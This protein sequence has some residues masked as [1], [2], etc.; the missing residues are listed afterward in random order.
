MYDAEL[1][2]MRDEDMSDEQYL[3]FY[4][5]SREEMK[6]FEIEETE[7][8]P[9]TFDLIDDLEVYFDRSYTP[10]ER[11]PREEWAEKYLDKYKAVY[12]IH[13]DRMISTRNLIELRNMIGALPITSFG[14][15]DRINT[16]IRIIA[17]EDD[18]VLGPRVRSLQYVHNPS[19]NELIEDAESR[20]YDALERALKRRSA[21]RGI[22]RIDSERLLRQRMTGLPDDYL[23]GFL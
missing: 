9:I 8:Y 14:W 16:E 20:M 21:N 5:F 4:G 13:Y 12:P 18:Y 10:I 19:Y 3:A 11:L 2:D 22:S 6:E 7:L 23:R 1:E 17:D 15:N